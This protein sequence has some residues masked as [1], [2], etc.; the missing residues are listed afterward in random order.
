MQHKKGFT[1]IELMI[2]ISI[3]GVLAAVAQPKVSA[4]ISK[5]RV[6]EFPAVLH[7]IRIAEDVYYTV[8]SSYGNSKMRSVDGTLQAKLGVD[9]KS[10][11]FSYTVIPTSLSNALSADD[12]SKYGQAYLV[13]C[14]VI[15]SVGKMDTSTVIFIDNSEIKYAEPASPVYEYARGWVGGS[16]LTDYDN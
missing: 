5:A 14:K 1:L 11:F 2:V 6:S 15:K 8:H 16:D 12:A 4:A 3:V 7:R 13:G 9:P 10:T